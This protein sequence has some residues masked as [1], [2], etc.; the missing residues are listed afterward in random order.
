[1]SSRSSRTALRPV[2]TTLGNFIGRSIVYSAHFERVVVR[3]LGNVDDARVGA[4]EWL[5]AQTPSFAGFSTV[6]TH[7]SEGAIFVVATAP[8][9]A[10]PRVFVLFT[11]ASSGTVTLW[12]L[13]P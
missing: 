8:T 5:L 4:I 3:V 1:M 2:V 13:V 12:D 9:P 11:V 7:P 10:F 6:G